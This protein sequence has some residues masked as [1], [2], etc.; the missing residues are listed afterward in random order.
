MYKGCTM[1]AHRVYKL[2]S[3]E[4]PMSIPCTPLVHGALAGVRDGDWE[5]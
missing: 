3:Y 5:H 4:H 2:K 1:D